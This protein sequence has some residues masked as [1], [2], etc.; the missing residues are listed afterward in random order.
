MLLE[1]CSNIN[2]EIHRHT[3]H[4]IRRNI[5]SRTHY[6]DY[7]L[8]I[9]NCFSQEHT[10]STP[11]F[12][13]IQIVTPPT[14]TSLNLSYAPFQKSPSAF[15]FLFEAPLHSANKACTLRRKVAYCHSKLA[16]IP[17][18]RILIHNRQNLPYMSPR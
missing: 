10:T 15:Q 6:P 1:A 14:I 17:I 13:F 11:I 12:H 8:S 18:S 9:F 2:D 16:Q 3:A 4:L 5:P 7:H